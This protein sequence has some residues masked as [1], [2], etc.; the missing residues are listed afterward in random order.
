MYLVFTF[1]KFTVTYVMF[2]ACV[3]LGVLRQDTYLNQARFKQKCKYLVLHVY[4][5]YTEVG[6]FLHIYYEFLM[7]PIKC[8]R[9]C[10]S[11]TYMGNTR[12]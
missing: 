4:T 5:G 8:Q 9:G 7:K 12:L 10:A 3:C 6:Y 2:V 11:S 1:H